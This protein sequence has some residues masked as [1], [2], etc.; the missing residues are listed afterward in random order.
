MLTTCIASIPEVDSP[1]RYSRKVISSK[2]SPWDTRDELEGLRDQLLQARSNLPD[3]LQPTKQNLLFRATTSSF[4]TFVMLHAHWHQILCDLYRFLV[5][6]RR[7]SV[8]TEAFTATPPA[9][10]AHCQQQCLVTARE[11]IDFFA[12]IHDLPERKRV[13]DTFFG[14]IA[15]HCAL[16]VRTLSGRFPTAVDLDG[17]PLSQQL[18]KLTDLLKESE[19]SNA[20]TESCVRSLRTQKLPQVADR[21]ILQRLPTS[22]VSYRYWN[23]MQGMITK[24]HASKTR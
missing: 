16:I 4:T 5:P 21:V 9:F 20:V 12:Q 14:V 8:T 23:V 18:Q 7:E 1:F 2:Q 24:I 22:R 3:E 11:A 6:G 15:Y 17:L 19:Q 10:A 13:D